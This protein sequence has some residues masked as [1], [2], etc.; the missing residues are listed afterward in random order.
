[1][2]V[3]DRVDLAIEWFGRKPELTQQELWET[4]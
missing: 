4:A 3:E 1:M 2:A